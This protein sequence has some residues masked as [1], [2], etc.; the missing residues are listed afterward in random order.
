W[1][2]MDKGSW[3]GD[4]PG[5]LPAHMAAWPKIQLGFISGP[6]LETAPLGVSAILVDPTE[7]SSNNVHAIKVPVGN[8]QN[9]TQ[10]YLVEVRKQI[11]F[12]SAL[13]GAGVLI[14]FVNDHLSIG[15]VELI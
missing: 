8:S 1:E 2:L 7:I 4:P 15:K 6:L 12:D 13:P 10:Y 14:T 11:G 3:N 9:S 5:S